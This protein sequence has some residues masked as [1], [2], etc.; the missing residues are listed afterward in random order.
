MGGEAKPPAGQTDQ[1]TPGGKP[2]KAA[3]DDEVF[4]SLDGK[5]LPEP[6]G[7]LKRK[8]ETKTQGYFGPSYG[9]SLLKLGTE[10]SSVE[11]ERSLIK[12]QIKSFFPPLL[13]SAIAGDAYVLPPNTFRV[14]V[15]YSFTN[16]ALQEIVWVTDPSCVMLGAPHGGTERCVTSNS[17][18]PFWG[19]RPRGL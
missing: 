8:P 2:P 7:V 10:E 4:R 1:S 19:C 14:G 11:V 9:A 18:K 15:H 17:I 3:A 13:Q 5:P 6:E 12:A 16:M